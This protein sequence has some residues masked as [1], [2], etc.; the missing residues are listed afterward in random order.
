MRFIFGEYSHI[1]SNMQ[2][3]QYLRDIYSL[4]IVRNNLGLVELKSID[5]IAIDIKPVSLSI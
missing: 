1:I 3:D 4:I 2:V 5:S